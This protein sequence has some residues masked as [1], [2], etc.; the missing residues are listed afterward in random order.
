MGNGWFSYAVL[1]LVCLERVLVESH[2]SSMQEGIPAKRND[3]RVCV[4]V[5]LYRVLVE[6]SV[7]MRNGWFYYVVLPL[8]SRVGACE[9]QRLHGEWLDVARCSRKLARASRR[10]TCKP[11]G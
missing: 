9:I 4:C 8:V 3:T 11:T 6:L 1:R 7:Y 2:R 10:P 5:C